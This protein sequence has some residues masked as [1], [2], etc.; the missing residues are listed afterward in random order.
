MR[1]LIGFVLVGIIF[2][3]CLIFVFVFTYQIHDDTDVN[4]TNMVNDWLKSFGYCVLLEMLVSENIRIVCR[5]IL[6]WAKRFDPEEVLHTNIELSSIE[7]PK[8]DYEFE[9]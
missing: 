3:I 5:A 6:I 8:N 4:Y 9:D 2:F 1:K 7:R